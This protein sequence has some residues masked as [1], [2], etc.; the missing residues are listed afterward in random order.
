MKN[1]FDFNTPIDR[2]ASGSYKW[3]E[4]VAEGAPADFIPLWVADM[5]FQAAPAIRRALADRVAHG[6]FG[7]TQVTDAYYEAILSWFFRR[8]GWAIERADIL[9]TSG[10]VPALSCAIKALAMRLP[11]PRVPAGVRRG[12]LSY[13]LGILRS[14]LRPGKD[15]A[16]PPLQSAQ[17]GRSR[18][19][20]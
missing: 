8:H 13:R 2:R 9:Y 18:L 5:D 20:A 19:D 14:L 7:Y 12:Y 10:V 16:L 6:V 11:G 3:D 1:L 4:P 15:H 17:P